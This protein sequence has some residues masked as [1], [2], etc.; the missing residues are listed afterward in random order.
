MEFPC[1][2][3][4]SKNLSPQSLKTILPI[5]NIH[6]AVWRGIR[7]MTANHNREAHEHAFHAL[8][9]QS[10]GGDG[11]DLKT[12]LPIENIHFA[13][14]RGIRNMTANHNREAHEHAFHALCS[15]SDGGDGC[16]LT[17]GQ[18]L[19]VTKPKNDALFFLIFPSRNLSED[20][21]DSLELKT[22]AHRLEAVGTG[23]SWLQL[24]WLH[25][26]VGQARA[27]LCGQCRLEM[28]VDDIRRDHLQESVNGI[29]VARLERPQ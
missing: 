8:C 24:D 5:E 21:L 1:K 16:D 2:T 20:L 12:I 28:I 29:F 14:W 26:R 7:N 15:Q 17:G 18:S 4:P 19:A 11:C 22:A 13:V 27:P 25:D 3:F 6:F 10:D 23:R 9:S